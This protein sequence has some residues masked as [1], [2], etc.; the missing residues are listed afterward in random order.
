MN[1]NN[2]DVIKIFTTKPI[3]FNTAGQTTG[4]YIECAGKF[5]LLQRAAGQ[6]HEGKWG[7]PGGKLEVGESPD[8]AAVREL[9]EETGIRI[10][11]GTSLQS[12]GT[13]YVRVAKADF[14]YHLYKIVLDVMPQV[15]LS[16]EHSKYMWATPTEIASLNLMLGEDKAIE[17]ILNSKQ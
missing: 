16:L 14:V 6:R 2:N 7:S 15:C 4:C 13:F 3:D 5:L 10:E 11:F 8:A 9:F 12:F 17:I 1:Q